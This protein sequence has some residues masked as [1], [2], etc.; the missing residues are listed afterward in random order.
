M[1]KMESFFLQ[2][3]GNYLPNHTVPDP[4]KGSNLHCPHHENLKSDMQQVFVL[5]SAP[6]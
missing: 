5:S 2:N 3:I 4:K 1:L 6:F